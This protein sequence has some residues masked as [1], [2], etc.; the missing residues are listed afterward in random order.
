MSNDRCLTMTNRGD[1]SLRITVRLLSLEFST[2]RRKK[3]KS[4]R[5][6]IH[7]RNGEIRKAIMISKI[8][9]EKDRN[10]NYERTKACTLFERGL[11]HPEPGGSK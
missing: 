1:R 2:I 11:Q 10:I 7:G 4:N 8:A 9:G 3:N 5:R 6:A